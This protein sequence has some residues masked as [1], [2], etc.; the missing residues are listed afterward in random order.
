M[1]F[2]KAVAH[3]PKNG[4][5]YVGFGP[6]LDWTEVGERAKIVE[7][8]YVV[9]MFVGE[10]HGF[11]RRHGIGSAGRFVESGGASLFIAHFSHTTLVIGEGAGAERVLGNEAQ[12]LR[13]KIGAAVDEQEVMVVGLQQCRTA[14]AAIARIGRGAHGASASHLWDARGGAGAE[15]VKF[16]V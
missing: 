14:R 11:E 6:H 5:G 16:H 7:S 15:K 3:V 12:H 9:E 13:A 4:G 2:P 8:R 1:V 10:E